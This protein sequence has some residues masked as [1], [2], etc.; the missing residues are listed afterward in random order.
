MDLKTISRREQYVE[1]GI[2]YQREI[3]HGER[4]VSQDN[5]AI[6]VKVEEILI[7]L[8]QL[9]SSSKELENAFKDVAVAQ[10]PVKVGKYHV[11]FFEWVLSTIKTARARVE[12]SVGWMSAISSKKSKREYWAM[13]KKHG[14]TF[15]LSNE[16]VVAT[17]VG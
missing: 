1:P 12:E 15:G 4:R 17:Q 5:R 11:N 13:F 6:E 2:D 16:R 14:T 9:I 3:V 7:E 10:A 8:K